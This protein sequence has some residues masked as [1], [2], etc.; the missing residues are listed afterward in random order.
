M[1]QDSAA[2]SGSDLRDLFEEYAQVYRF[3]T[4]ALPHAAE[5]L[6]DVIERAGLGAHMELLDLACG[7]G[8]LEVKMQGLGILGDVT[9]LDFSE[10]M[11]TQARLGCPEARF[12]R[13][14]LTHPAATWGVT[15]P[16]DAVACILGLNVVPDPRHVMQGA[17]E[18]L[19]PGGVFVEATPHAGSDP[20]LVWAR[21]LVMAAELGRSEAEEMAYFGPALVRIIKL[22]QMASQVQH[23]P[24]QA[25]ILAR[26]ADAGLKV[27]YLG[28]TYADQATLVVSRKE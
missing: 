25:E 6:P 22:S 1:T 10:S 20:R 26:H 28:S 3:T 16:F 8:A 4:E 21:H 27:E 14:D 11:L 5:L 7:T 19:A 24:T 9:G 23:F 17:V 13:A 12:R 18:L 2:P 15:G